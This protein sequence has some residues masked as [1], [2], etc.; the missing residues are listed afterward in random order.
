MQEKR[1]L[2]AKQMNIIN[3]TAFYWPDSDPQNPA[4]SADDVLRTGEN[5]WINTLST[6]KL[7]LICHGYSHPDCF[8]WYSLFL[9]VSIRVTYIQS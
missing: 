9:H 1:E 8:L 2:L 7:G 4:S 5:V 3:S 6:G